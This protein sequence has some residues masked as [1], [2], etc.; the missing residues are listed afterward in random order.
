MAVIRLL[1]EQPFVQRLFA[2]TYFAS[3]GLLSRQLPIRCEDYPAHSGRN[4]MNTAGSALR[5]Y[6]SPTMGC[7]DF[8]QGLELPRRR[9]LTRREDA[10]CRHRREMRHPEGFQAMS[11]EGI[12]ERAS[13]NMQE[14][15]AVPGVRDCK[16]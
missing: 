15:S 10:G 9:C 8:Q 5:E 2:R 3:W 1:P 12:P 16:G 4:R 11:A 6:S 13:L 14:P 7:W